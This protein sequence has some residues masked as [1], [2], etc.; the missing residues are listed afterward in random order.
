[1][2]INHFNH[3]QA[4][5]APHLQRG[6]IAISDSSPVG[7][8][9]SPL[10]YEVDSQAQGLG[11]Q[12]KVAF[13]GANWTRRSKSSPTSTMAQ[14][15]PDLL[16]QKPYCAD[17]LE[18]GLVIRSRKSALKRRHIQLNTPNVFSW[19]HFDQDSAEGYFAADDGN[20][21][22]PTFIAENPENGH[23]H[24]AYLLKNPVSNFAA[25]RSSPLHYL[26]AVER[27]MR[28]RLGADPNYTALIAKN[29]LH[30]DWRVEWQARQPY[31]LSELADWLWP[32]DTVPEP[33]RERSGFGRNCDVFDD[34]RDFAYKNVIKFKRDVGSLDAWIE[35]CQK[36]AAGHNLVFANQLPLSEIRAI[37]KSIAKWTWRT[38]SQQRFSEIQAWRGKRRAAKRWAGHTAAETTKPWLADGISRRTWYRRKAKAK[39]QRV[40]P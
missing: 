1:M 10:G 25:S 23:A 39:A 30:P 21:L 31:D 28:R 29:P 40:A 38:F 8:V 22:A 33:K 27:G 34:T 4:A 5:E 12:E 35:R 15:F 17:E 11:N 13:D 6:T 16:P 7:G 24:I 2:Q 3:Y 20:L 36:I 14:I 9:C 18:Y 37:G 26:A 19:L 32:R